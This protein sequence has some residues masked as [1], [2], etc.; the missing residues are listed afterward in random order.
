M[1]YIKSKKYQFVFSYESKKGKKWLYRYRYYNNFN[2][3]KEASKQGFDTEKEAYK[4]LLEVQTKAANGSFK[5][6]SSDRLK[7]KDWM[8]IW[9]ETF[10]DDWKINSQLQRVNAIENHINPLIGDYTLSTLDLVTYK[11]KFI[12]PLLEKYKPGT[13]D[14]L[15]SI[16]MIAVNAAVKNESLDRNRIKEV[17]IPEPT[18]SENYLTDKELEHFINTAK[19]TEN[20]TN[21][22]LVLVLAYSGMR[23]GEALGLT[24]DD[25]D[26]EKNTISINRTRDGKGTRT[27]KTKN[28][29]RTIK[30]SPVIM[31][32]VKKYLLWVKTNRLQ[33]G[34]PY[35]STDFLF[36]SY[37][38]GD[39]LSPSTPLYVFR[40]LCSKSGLKKLSP[41]G[42]RHTHATLLLKDNKPVVSVAKRLGNT[43]DMINNIYGHVIEA[44]EDDL[45]DSFSN[46]LNIQS[47]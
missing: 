32:Q 38:T 21:Y 26:F 44:M 9:Y 23:I 4:A 18:K 39:P 42:L 10:E 25:L 29:Y 35:K 2:E 31:Q 15:H 17:Y 30:M 45:V 1:N 20:I 22:T 11:T 36:C 47:L 13:V 33:F 43:P 28:S 41:H 34:K 12:K 3:R 19:E 46:S 27:P 16:F 40:R 7:V 6:L 14:L 8:K 24:E 5:E 37:Q